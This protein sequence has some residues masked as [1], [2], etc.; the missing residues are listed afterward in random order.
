MNNKFKEFEKLASPLIDYLRDNHNPHTTIIITYNDAEILEGICVV[1]RLE[2]DEDF[3]DFQPKLI[4]SENNG[5]ENNSQTKE[6]QLYGAQ[7]VD[8]PIALQDPNRTSLSHE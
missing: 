6:A 2:D 1:N 7:G 3:N 4:T 5:S 8:P